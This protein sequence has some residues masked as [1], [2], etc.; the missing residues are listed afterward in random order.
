M[1]GEAA[2]SGL[3]FF[4]D[5]GLGAVVVPRALRAA[6]WPLET[7]DERYGADQ[8]QNIRDTQWIEEATF[9]GDILLCKDLAIAPQPSGGASH[10]HDK[11]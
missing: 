1:A 10:L 3:Q 4:L 9:A 6:G 7:M 8:S 11:R 2:V 5:R